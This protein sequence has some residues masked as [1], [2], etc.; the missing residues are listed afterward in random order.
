M[1]IESLSFIRL[2]YLNSKTVKNVLLVIYFFSSSYLAQDSTVS[3]TDLRG[4]HSSAS[5]HAG[6]SGESDMTCTCDGLGYVE[7]LLD[8][9][10]DE[11]LDE[12][13]W[14]DAGNELS[15]FCSS[16]DSIAAELC[17]D[18]LDSAASAA[19]CLDESDYKCLCGSALD[20]YFSTMTSCLQSHTTGTTSCPAS[21][22][23][24]YEFLR[25]DCEEFFRLYRTRRL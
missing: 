16:H 24:S 21:S 22:A 8:C 4:C 15:T 12:S 20:T 7:A 1:M 14:S 13:L 11:S 5:E 18:C 10:E 6:C 9:A 25:S 23:E 3:I 19:S 2:S 17:S